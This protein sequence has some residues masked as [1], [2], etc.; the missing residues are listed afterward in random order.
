M[1]ARWAANPG[2]GGMSSHPSGSSAR[3][4][5]D[6][7]YRP[8][9]TETHAGNNIT[10]DTTMIVTQVTVG[11]GERV[12]RRLPGG[13]L[14]QHVGVAVVPGRAPTRQIPPAQFPLSR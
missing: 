3:S 8:G 4:T 1:P 10:E 9:P 6:P 12:G 13:D 5:M 7:R 2:P 11:D 14:Q